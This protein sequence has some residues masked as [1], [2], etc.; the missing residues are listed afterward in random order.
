ML[1]R[2]GNGPENEAP[3]AAIRGKKEGPADLRW[4]G[5]DFP[6]ISRKS[7]T[8]RWELTLPDYWALIVA[9]NASFFGDFRRSCVGAEINPEMRHSYPIL[10]S[11]KRTPVIDNTYSVISRAIWGKSRMS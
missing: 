8:N 7:R 4:V 3:L 10:W 11:R 6:R 5:R 2:G 1:Y 9:K